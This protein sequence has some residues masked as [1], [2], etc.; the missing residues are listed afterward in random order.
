L[1][2]LSRY[3]EDIHRKELR[4]IIG[5]LTFY[6]PKQTEENIFLHHHFVFKHQNGREKNIK[7]VLSLKYVK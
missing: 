3:P 7:V 5:I 6:L 2:I 1:Y 4:H